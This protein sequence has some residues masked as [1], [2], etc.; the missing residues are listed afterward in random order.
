MKKKKETYLSEKV[1]GIEDIEKI[2]QTAYPPYRYIIK[3]KTNVGYRSFGAN[4]D[5]YYD[6]SI[7]S[8]RHTIYQ[9]IL[10]QYMSQDDEDFSNELYQF[11]F[12]DISEILLI[13][14]GGIR[15]KWRELPTF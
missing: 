1:K 12:E 2:K 7:I 8:N 15:E 6:L 5:N 14:P 9:N 11:T 13:A 10:L 3:A 4:L